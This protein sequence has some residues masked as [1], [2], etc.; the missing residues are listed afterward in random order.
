MCFKQGWLRKIST[1]INFPFHPLPCKVKLEPV[2]KL[3]QINHIT[4]KNERTDDNY[5]Y[6]V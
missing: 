2:C 3:G 1:N 4:M 5:L 6:P